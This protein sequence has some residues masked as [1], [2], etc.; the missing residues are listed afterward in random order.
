MRVVITGA[1]G[2]LGRSLQEVFAGEDIIPLKKA[3]LD[4]RKDEAIERLVA[5]RP[6]L[7]LHAAAMT[8]VDGC[9]LDPAAAMEINGEGTR[10]VA[11]AC[12]EGGAVLVYISTDYVFD[13][14]RDEPYAE[15]DP[16]NPIN[17]YGRSKLE[18]EKH[19]QALVV[20]HYIVRTAWL[21]GRG[22]E[23][24]VEKVIRRA[25]EQPE[26]YM[27]TN[28]V[29]SPTYTPDLAQG[30][31]RLVQHKQYGIFHLTNPGHCSRYEFAKE[32]LQLAGKADY[33]LYPSKGYERP[34][35][36]PPHAILANNRAAALGITLRPW[37]EAL[38]AYFH[39]RN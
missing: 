34:A 35:K 15:Q 3:D 39:E 19:V 7:V 9:E 11:E 32:I 27:V 17:V 4:I 1:G 21:Y 23:N 33:P 12:E 38:A 29:G 25:R 13:G 8:D 18:G 28:E 36:P 10:R 20:K 2:Q 16:S 26:M 14:Q 22:R 5:L 31:W 6:D 24:F 37:E 30:I